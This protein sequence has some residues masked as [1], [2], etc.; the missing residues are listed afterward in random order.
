MLAHALAF[1]HRGISVFPCKP[2]G[3]VPITPHGCQ[4]ATTDADQI[5]R[6]WKQNPLC[7]IGIATGPKSGI[8][9]LDIDGIEGEATLSV[10]EQRY[11]AELPATVEV[12][13]GSCGR[14]DYFRWP[15]DGLPIKNS[16]GKI[17][18]GIDARGQGGYVIAPP[19]IHPSGR[20]Y[21][22]SVDSASEFAN[23]PEWLLELAH[24]RHLNGAH[25]D[26]PRADDYWQHL[27]RE[28]AGEGCRNA[29]TAS[30]AGYLLRHG[31]KPSVAFELLLKWNACNRPP[32]PE[33]EL[34]N[35][36]RSIAKCELARRDSHG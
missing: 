11:D 25:G 17:G 31:I 8:W 21:A 13:T 26:A 32:L 1:A 10:L 4:D 14:H 6:W 12:I 20:R 35:T 3:K 28:G 7:N 9:V 34:V 15:G 22:W 2:R 19:S 29:S 23:A 33:Q 16:A 36:I 18:P 30:L 27:I 5:A 24:E